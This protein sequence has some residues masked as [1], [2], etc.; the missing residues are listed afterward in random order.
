[1]ARRFTKQ[2]DI[3]IVVDYCHHNIIIS[4]RKI[5]LFNHEEEETILHQKLRRD[6][7]V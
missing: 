6:Y 4:R 5:I 1:M 3:N 7:A 2:Y